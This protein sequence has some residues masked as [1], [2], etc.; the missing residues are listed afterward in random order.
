M[1]CAAVL[2]QAVS[3]IC[4]HTE[5]QITAAWSLD[6]CCALL[7][8]ISSWGRTA[9]RPLAE[10]TDPFVPL[11]LQNLTRHPLCRALSP[12][13]SCRA[14]APSCSV[15]YLGRA[16]A[17]SCPVSFILLQGTGSVVFCLLPLQGTGPVAPCLLHTPAGHRLRRVLSLT[18]AGH[19]PR[20]AL[21]P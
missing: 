13:Y 6:G 16:P 8:K 9:L 11:G 21:S 5:P 17:P 15:S 1:C 20:R 2:V 18:F 19:R 12:S 4:H 10:G 3:S 14:P 7:T